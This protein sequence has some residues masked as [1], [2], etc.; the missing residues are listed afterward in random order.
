MSMKI[1]ILTSALQ[2]NNYRG[3]GWIGACIEHL[4]AIPEIELG[5]GYLGQPMKANTGGISFYP[6][7]I[8]NKRRNRLKRRFHLAADEELL[9]PEI[10]RIIDDFHPDIIHVFG[11]ETPWGVIASHTSIP[12]LIHLQ[13]FQPS[14]YNAKYPP[15][16]DFQSIFLSQ[17][18]RNPVDALNFRWR[19]KMYRHCVAREFS[20]IETGKYFCGRTDWDRA[21]VD[22]IHPEAKYFY[23]SEFLRQPFYDHAGQWERRHKGHLKILS[24]I[25]PATFKGADVILK[26]AKWLQNFTDIDFSWDVYGVSGMDWNDPYWGSLR[27]GER[28][29][30]H[31]LASAEEIVRA[32]LD[33][34]VFV[35]TSYIDNSPNS[36]CEAQLLGMPVIGTNAGGVSSLIRDNFDGLLVPANDPLMMANRIKELY[37]NPEKAAELGKNAANTA[38]KRHAPDGI[39]KDLVGIY[40]EILMQNDEK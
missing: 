12:V 4:S 40:H 7:P 13:G 3:C 33:A 35:H 9:I 11:S 8:W 23:C 17:L 16:Q 28:V 22:V 39:V 34:D 15:G 5:I 14:Y 1:L 36:I 10:L 27:S 32:G 21:I 20:V 2:G 6:I 19:E 31:G 30:A 29:K 25:S 18:F 38:Q 37:E 24:V 26:T